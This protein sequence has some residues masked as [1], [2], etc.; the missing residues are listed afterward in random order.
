MATNST[1]TAAGVDFLSGGGET[2]ALMRAHDWSASPLG[3][4]EAWPQ[5]LRT[6]VGL[7]LN[8]LQPM[9][10]A[11]GPRRILLYNDG[12]APLCGARH[13]W[14]LG[15][16]FAEVW[17]DIIDDVGPIMD[18]TYAGVSTHMD[19]IRF[20]MHRN[21]YPEE[22]NFTFSYTPVRDEGGEVAGMFCV[23]TETT[24]R[25]AAE[26]AL[27]E[28]VARQA[29]L[30]RLADR[31]RGLGDP[32]AIMAAAVEML[33]AHLGVGR[34]G[35]A[36]T[37][38]TA[39]HLDVLVDW[40]DGV[41]PSA[42]GRVP[43]AVYGMEIVE[44][45]RAGRPW[46][47]EDA[48]TDPRP[49]VRRAL[50][51]YL[52]WGSRAVIGVPLTKAG[53]WVA[54]LFVHSPAARAWTPSEVELVRDVAERTWDAVERARAETRLR[55]GEAKYR[56]LFEAMDEGYMLADVVFDEAERSVDVHYLEANPA[57]TRM[58]G[59]DCTG[60]R[61]SEIDPSFE[62][63][64][65]EIWG[66]VAR[67]GRGERL[68]RYAEP[69]NAW[70]D[71]YIFRTG[72]ADSRR[73][74]VV[75]EDV[76]GRKRVEE[77]L[78]G[79]NETLEQRVAD[80][81]AER[82]VLADVV[83]ST[84][85]FIQVLDLDYRILAINR[86]NADEFERLYGVRPRVGDS[87]MDL[88]AGEPEHRERLRALWGRALAGEEFSLVDEFS[89]PGHERRVYEIKFNVLRDRD[90][91]RI[92]AYHFVY[93]VT[94][95]QQGQMRLDAAEEQLRQAQ[96]M[97]T[98]GQLT[99]GVAHDFNNLLQALSGCLS[100]IGRRTRETEVRPLIEAGQQAVDRGAKLVQQLMAFARPESL[101][102]QPIDVRERVVGMSELLARALRADIRLATEFSPGLWPVEVDPTQFELALINL[103]VNARD[104]MPEGGDLA[105]EASN[106]HLS[107]PDAAGLVGDFV[108]LSVRD[109]GTGMPEEV[110]ARVFEPFYTTKEVG[111]GS[112]LG[113]SQ[114]YGFARQAGGTA[115]IESVPGRGTVVTML[116]RRS[117]LPA[118]VVE[119]AAPTVANAR[120]R[121]SILVVE[122]DEVVATTV[123]AALEDAGYAVAWVATADEALS[124]LA[125][126]TPF[127]LVFS[128]VVMPGRLSGLDLVQAAR[129]LRPDLPVV[130]T[131]GYSEKLA[132]AE[133]V[134]VLAKPY[135]I[136]DL[137]HALDAA[138]DAAGP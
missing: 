133:G 66:R 63:Y 35:Y 137:V 110:A 130:L 51:D 136:D 78:R 115:R 107:T 95:R 64:W 3:S 43:I 53:H 129:H 86:A 134:H 113:L 81:L 28:S 88:L 74:A 9:F 41:Q 26:T 50:A 101:R 76:T 46:V 104:A 103:A 126:G 20:T 69:L 97:E 2:G 13:P 22:A 131:T 116:L 62:P 68:E 65:Y 37:D 39:A 102:P 16:P 14:A 87:L 42:V 89:H 106:L 33:G 83:E 45:Y 36:E 109:T 112:G 121:G 5:P 38:D 111:K 90:G 6:L 85:A 75:F 7:M 8:S 80:A 100:M 128:D 21:G 127:D 31:T 54:A 60:L 34:V 114:V 105:I 138:M 124:L 30:L 18:R 96:K 125:G 24:Q 40:T 99:G 61:M 49:E 10:V 70:F 11:W 82:K 29:F 4:P 123:A 27:R 84:G 135:R 19:D 32:E 122:D 77:E 57:A 12:Y 119:A 52:G 94:E 56:T 73:V 117:A 23:C 120:R 71:F 25:V 118:P 79:L 98:V 93:D 67:T 44:A 17:H 48:G 108:R 55:E 132:R 72:G 47:V 59:R 15:R 92:G 91:R 58:L 1:L